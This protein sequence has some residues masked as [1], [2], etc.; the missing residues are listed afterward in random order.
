MEQILK[1]L[2]SIS[3]KYPFH[4]KTILAPSYLDG[5]SFKK[6]LTL[7]GFSALNFNITTLFDVA[8]DIYFPVLIKNEWK[9]LDSTI[10][11]I[12]VFDIIKTLSSEEKLSYFKLPLLTPSLAASIF[13][14]IKE[15]RVSGY[16]AH[17]FPQKI[18]TISP[19]MKDLFLI[20]VEYERKLKEE[21]LIDEAELYSLAERLK[22][23]KEEIIYLIP[24]NMPMN[25]VELRFYKKRIKPKS[26][27][28]HFSCPEASTAPHS[29]PITAYGDS[30]QSYEEY[31]YNILQHRENIDFQQLPSLALEFIQTYGEYNETREVLRKIIK[32]E[33]PF[34]KVQVF[35]TTQEP[36]SQYFYQLSLLY[37]IPMTFHS[38]ISIKNSCPAQFLFSLFDW[39]IDNYS[40]AKLITLLK[41]SSLDRNIRSTGT[42]QKFASLLRQSPI[43]WGRER[44][45]PGFDLAIEE[46]EKQINNTSKEKAKELSDDIQHLFTL[47]EWIEELFKEIPDQKFEHLISLS[48][49]AGGLLRLVKKYAQKEKGNIDEEAELIIEHTLDALQID[50]STQITIN[51][52]LLLIKNLIEQER[53]NCSTPLPGHLHI[54]SYKKGIWIDRLYTFL[55]GM[56]YQ[57]FPGNSNGETLLLETEIHP[58]QH[59]LNN[60]Q[61]NK[62]EQLRLLQL[63]LSRREKICLSFSGY[64]TTA[65][66]E[67]SPANLFFQLFRFQ[68]KNINLDYSI[69]YQDLSPARSFIPENSIEI[70]DEGEFFLYFAKQ[71]KMDLQSLYAQKYITFWEGIRADRIRTEGGFNAYNGNIQVN[72]DITDPRKNRGIVLS[73]SKLERIAYCPYLYFLLDILKIKPPKEMAYDP[74]TWLDPLER[75]LLLHKIFE[76]FY[77]ILLSSSNGRKVAPSYSQHWNLL[78]ETA[79]E[80]LAERRRY[81]APPGELVYEAEKKE[82]L[83]SCQIFL[84]EEEEIHK[85][86]SNHPLYFELAFGTRDNEHEILGK[87]KAIELKIPDGN[88]IS[89]QGKIDRVDVLPD[90]TFLVIDYKTG[91][92]R[93]YKKKNP[94]RH[95]QQI[96]HALYAMAVEDILAK[97]EVGYELKVSESGY[98]FPT[99]SGLGN[100]VLYQ[101]HNREQVLEIIN[102]LLDLVTKGNFAMIQKAEELI[103]KDYRE[104]MEQNQVIPVKGTKGEIYDSEPALEEIKRLQQFE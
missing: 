53:I 55:V 33:Y 25:E 62:I 93:D 10:G 15:I 28:L 60:N 80:S 101:Q 70:L 35:Y 48:R 39:I 104:I 102:I 4:K 94:F 18:Q 9:I 84:K 46:R 75:G 6:N 64:H 92:S 13:R 99:T 42:E 45:L 57:K 49:L 47:K 54:A 87:I 89:I 3:Q 91:S 32:E 50:I 51:E 26:I 97:K 74:F 68:K 21:R 43:G 83:E 2:Q 19:K 100:I 58:F 23:K 14:T 59:L 82:I 96:Q 27:L 78:K 34:D 41:Y 24:A 81:L 88:R 63:I 44:Y 20:M 86:Y 52:S 67:Q 85:R 12:L 16:S 61:K 1:H 37:Q 69:F 11:Q 103:C 31:F 73:A 29:F 72:A 40:I 76:R 36:Y 79:E 98:Y 38:G 65:Q 8:R 5:N 95:G 90:G 71:E 7:K 22:P 66:R 77:R 17:N 30:S 56:D